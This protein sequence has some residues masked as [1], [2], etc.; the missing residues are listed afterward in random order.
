MHNIDS[1]KKT[2]NK[3]DNTH[4]QEEHWIPAIKGK[5]MLSSVARRGGG[6]AVT[7]E[8]PQKERSRTECKRKR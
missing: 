6:I 5:D 7:T 8:K 1:S 2:C 4:I 3:L